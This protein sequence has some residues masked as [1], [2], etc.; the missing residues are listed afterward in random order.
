MM[1]SP[2]DEAQ[3]HYNEGPHRLVMI[4]EAFA[5][6]RYA[7]TFNEWDFAQTDKAWRKITGLEPRKPDDESWGRGNRP[8]VNVSWDD[9]KAYVKWLC[10]KTGRAY[11]LL[12][13][14]EWEY[15]CRAGTETPFWWGSSIAPDQANYDGGHAYAGGADGR[16]SR[17]CIASGYFRSEP[18]WAVS[19][20]RQC[21]G[22]VRRLLAR[23][24]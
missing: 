14:A 13:E 17:K 18:L 16:I 10:A 7:V 19:S 21:V 20:S 6:G 3:R 11:R 15:V 24:L 5:V 2:L 23:D 9:S 4:A 12:S 1:G 22:V 8:V